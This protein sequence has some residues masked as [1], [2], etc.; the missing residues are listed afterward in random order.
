MLGVKAYDRG[1]SLATWVAGAVP[2]RLMGDPVRIRQVI[3]N[4]TDNAL[5]FTKDGSVVIRV[6][7][8]SREGT[9]VFLRFEVEDT[10]IG[11]KPEVAAKLFQNFFQADSSTTRKYGGT[12]LGLSICRR[13]AE[14][15]GG[16]VGVQS[17]LGEGSL[18]WFTARLQAQ[19]G[20]Q[21][22]WLPETRARFFLVGLPEATGKVLDAQ[23]REWGFPS[24]RLDPGPAALD[25]LLG[26]SLHPEERTLLIFG[27]HGGM[28]P[29]MLTFLKGVRTEPSL[30]G[31]RLVMAHSLYE[32]EESR[33]P[34]DLAITEFLPLPM[35][36]SHL[37]T[38]LDP[39]RDLQP[40]P[41]APEALPVLVAPL[42]SVSLLL[43]EDNLV[44]QRV[45]VA[46]LKKM[47]LKPDLAVNGV[48]AVEACRGKTYDLILMDCQMPEMDGFQATRE[49]RS[50]E[51]SGQRV[52]ILAMTANAMQGDRERC[53]E[54][55]MD[56]YLSKPVAILDLK[57]ALQRW[58]PAA[59]IL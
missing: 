14:L 11:M 27:A 3:S 15:M 28:S 6:S 51:G 33:K 20:A 40:L 10:G 24:E 48:E 42:N 17:T 7:L 41:V 59:S 19:E 34:S 21:E 25:H 52:P 5:K 57:Q 50:L 13:I 4:L 55:G 12:G 23:L 39:H 16:E 54:A 30:A 8:E 37:K 47:G 43:A 58:L 36:K 44:N 35:R 45:A 2:T 22:A 32:K 56:D 38:L 31:V 26:C 49:I 18:F 9:S 29:E 46:V 1:V 53:L